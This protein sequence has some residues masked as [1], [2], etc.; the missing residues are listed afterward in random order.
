MR[1]APECADCPAMAQK[2]IAAYH[3]GQ[4]LAEEGVALLA[5]L[6]RESWWGEE[7]AGAGVTGV[8][9]DTDTDTDSVGF[10]T[11]PP[12]A[13]DDGDGDGR[14][15]KRRQPLEAALRRESEDAGSAM[16][17]AHRGAPVH[18]LPDQLQGER[19][20]VVLRRG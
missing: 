8:D 3:S 7:I 1:C 2:R 4:E 19:D 12:S 17:T 11:S 15:V 16:A 6:A 20:T 5:K 10:Y 14:E 13:W 9:I 18:V